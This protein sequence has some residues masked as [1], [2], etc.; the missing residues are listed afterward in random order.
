[1][2][3][4]LALSENTKAINLLIEVFANAA[5]SATVT[6]SDAAP[7]KKTRVS[8]AA[9]TA[10]AVTFVPVT[11]G[12]PANEGDPE[13]TRYFHIAEH[14]TVYKQLPGQPDC[15]LGG[16]KIVSGA[17]YLIQQAELAKKFP[18]AAAQQAAPAAATI[19]PIATA[20]VAVA[21]EGPVFADVITK[22][23]ELHK[24]HGNPGV[25]A[26]LTQYGVKG[27]SELNGKADNAT[28][29]AEADTV[30]MMGV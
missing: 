8:K 23:R 25:A 16:A 7:E 22:M 17:E 24:A 28:L 21:S 2:S 9:A 15:S 29:I 12:Y 19:E 10:A 3:L 1:M 4:E 13:G 30:L 5:T 18:T 26:I 27:V 11:S 20:P 14:N 6:N